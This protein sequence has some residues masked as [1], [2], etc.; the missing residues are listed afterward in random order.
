MAICAT[1]AS[2]SAALSG[3]ITDLSFS[4]QGTFVLYYL[5]RGK[6]AVNGT[7]DGCSDK[8]LVTLKSDDDIP[9]MEATLTNSDGDRV[10]VDFEGAIDG[11][12]FEGGT[13]KGFAFALGEGRMLPEFEA[14]TGHN[15]NL[16]VVNYAEMHTKLVPQLV[17]VGSFVWR[18]GG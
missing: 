3:C 5:Y 4:K 6:V 14:A 10:T 2:D 13:A 7:N 16:E 9:D 17:V 1:R 8:D 18:G 11:T 15:V 12:P